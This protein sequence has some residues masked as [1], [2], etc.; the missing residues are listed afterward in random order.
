[1]FS[2]PFIDNENAIDNRNSLNIGLPCTC[3][4]HQKMVNASNS[5]GIMMPII[6]LTNEQFRD[7]TNAV[8]EGCIYLFENDDGEFTVR[9]RSDGF[10][11]AT[12]GNEV[13]PV[14][15]DE[16]IQRMGVVEGE[17]STLE[18]TKLLYHVTSG[19][20]YGFNVMF[21]HQRRHRT[22]SDTLSKSGR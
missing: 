14:W 22:I 11:W 15:S 2:F 8:A 1:M 7:V 16:D 3:Y 13:Y 19:S 10:L 21:E 20:L 12:Q 18:L 17:H 4:P 6:V 9:E 5:N